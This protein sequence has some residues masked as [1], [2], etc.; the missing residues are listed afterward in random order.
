[1]RGWQLVEELRRRIG[2]ENGERAGNRDVERLLEVI[3]G[4]TMEEGHP[5]LREPYLYTFLDGRGVIR[6]P[7][8]WSRRV[9]DHAALLEEILHYLLEPY[10]DGTWGMKGERRAHSREET[11][12]EDHM[13]MWRFAHATAAGLSD[14]ELAEEGACPLADV[15]RFHELR[16]RG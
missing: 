1:M 15:A 8:G 9:Q 13:L 12:V 10:A 5:L 4:L 3:P 6:A 11:R 16:V 7:Q 2:L 14:E